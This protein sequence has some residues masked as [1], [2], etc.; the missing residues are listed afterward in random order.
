MA[1]RAIDFCEKHGRYPDSAAFSVCSKC[2]E[3]GTATPTKRKFT[4]FDRMIDVWVCVEC[5]GSNVKA[6]TWFDPNLRERPVVSRSNVYDETEKW[7]RTWCEDCGCECE[8]EQRTVGYLWRLR[9][10]H[11]FKPEGGEDNESDDR[12]L[13]CVDEFGDGGFSYAEETEDVS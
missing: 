10:R 6:Q 9:H 8:L 4:W 7:S 1:Q 13:D 3:E 5:K 12:L 11:E 2:E